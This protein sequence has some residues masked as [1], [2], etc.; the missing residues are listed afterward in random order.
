MQG[1]RLRQGGNLSAIL[2]AAQQTVNSCEPGSSGSSSGS[3]GSSSSSLLDAR[4]QQEQ[5]A[6]RQVAL[7]IY[8]G[9]CGWVPGQLEGALLS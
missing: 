8:W 5:S 4:S 1:L 2:S 7:Q 9:N 3:S 6:A